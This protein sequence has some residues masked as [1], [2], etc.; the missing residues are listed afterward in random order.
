MEDGRG[1]SFDTQRPS[2]KEKKV[3][4]SELLKNGEHIPFKN[5]DRSNSKHTEQIIRVLNR[6]RNQR[7]IDLMEQHEPFYFDR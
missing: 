5:V 7:R 2:P 6:A 3:S 4:I 1:T